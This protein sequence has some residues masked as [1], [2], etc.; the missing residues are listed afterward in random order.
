MAEGA[1]RRDGGSA[2]RDRS[3][4]AI[5]GFLRRSL[6][7]DP[8]SRCFRLVGERSDLTGIRGFQFGPGTAPRM[9]AILL[10]AMGIVIMLIGL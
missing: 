9:F 8:S 1:E 4:S 3:R 6:S 10:G 2:A 7:L 5:P